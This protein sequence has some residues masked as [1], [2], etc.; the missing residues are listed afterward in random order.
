MKMKGKKI[1]HCLEAVKL[2]KQMVKSMESVKSLGPVCGV[3]I[4][5]RKWSSEESNDRHLEK[6]ADLLGKLRVRELANKWD[7]SACAVMSEYSQKIGGKSF[8][9]RMK[10][11]GKKIAHC[12]E[13]VKLTKQ[14]VKWMESVKSL[15]P[16]CG[17]P[18]VPR[19]W[20]SEDSNDHHLEK[21]IRKPK[22]MVQTVHNFPL[23]NCGI[24]ESDTKPLKNLTNVHSDVE[25]KKLMSSLKPNKFGRSADFTETRLPS[26]KVK[27]WKPSQPLNGADAD[28]NVKMNSHVNIKEAGHGQQPKVTTTIHVSRVKPLKNSENIDPNGDQAKRLQP[29]EL[30]RNKSSAQKSE[31]TITS[32]ASRKETEKREKIKEAMHV[33]D[34]VY[35]QLSHENRMKINGEKIGNWRVPLEAAKLTKQ[36]LKWMEPV[37]SLGPICGVQIGDKFKYRAQLK[38]IGLHCQLQSGINY[39]N[40]E[41]KNLA[42]SIVDSHRYANETGSAD[43]LIYCGHGGHSGLKFLGPKS[44]QEDQELKLGNLALKNSMDERT[45]IRVIKKL[46][47]GKDEVFVYDGLY[48]ANHYTRHRNE[49]GKTMFKYHL[50]R[51]LGQPALH[52]MLNASC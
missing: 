13:S 45:V 3:P 10:M 8:S 36:M 43:M 18:I 48:V 11:K 12:L 2:T 25:N 34:Q 33:F 27:F 39:T 26:G 32:T 50:N 49:D 52:Q 46:K 29:E 47:F 24:K 1:A 51:V 16:V 41:G 37:K 44:L 15:G 31:V 17:V 28:V 4:V 23:A 22:L 30:R 5:P 20:S 35:P 40:I 9:S 42:I 6:L 38:M 19:K 7:A 21:L 14:M